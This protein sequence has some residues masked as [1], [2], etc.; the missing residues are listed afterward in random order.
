[1]KEDFN[2]DQHRGSYNNWRKVYCM[3][4]TQFLPKRSSQHSNDVN[5][6]NYYYQA[7][8]TRTRLQPMLIT[9]HNLPSLLANSTEQS[10]IL[11]NANT[12]YVKDIR[13]DKDT[14]YNTI[15]FQLDEFPLVS[16]EDSKTIMERYF[17]QK[18]LDYN[19]I[20]YIGR[21]L[22]F[23]KKCP[24]VSGF[25]V[26]VPETRTDKEPA[27]WYGLHHI[28]GEEEHKKGNCMHVQ[29]RNG[30]ELQ[31]MISGHS[32]REQIERSA[33]LQQLQDRL[34]HQTMLLRRCMS[35]QKFANEPNPIEKYLS[36]H[37]LHPTHVPLKKILFFMTNF[38]I[39]EILETVLGEENPYIDEI[40]ATFLKEIKNEP[41][42]EP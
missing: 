30:H 11:I 18:P 10:H 9:D 36:T 42:L 1:M 27:S 24:F 29:F 7:T 23:Y 17:N 2:H 20:Q 37:S 41:P 39:H 16:L 22:G 35:D 34:V 4:E 26:F 38:R 33:A 28:R 3:T 6:P 15:V 13:K 19:F 40:R 21:T 14:P 8:F 12:F 31:L 25:E 5:E 32:Y